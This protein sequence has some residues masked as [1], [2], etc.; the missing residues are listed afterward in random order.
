MWIFTT[1]GFFSIV[2]KKGEPLLTVRAR[3][4]SDLDR[5]REEY[6]PD[7]SE[8]ISGAGT[9]YLYR[10]TIGH[11]SFS[12]GIAKMAK[13]IH[14]DNFKN[15]IGKAM[16]KKRE[17]IYLEIWE[18]LLKL[19]KQEGPGHFP[20]V[21]SGRGRRIAYGG[22]V[23]NGEGKI[24]LREPKNHFD[25]YVWTFPKGSPNR[26]ESP[27]DTALREVFE[28]TG[29]RAKI[30]GRLPGNYEGGTSNNIYFLMSMIEDTGKLDDETKSIYW[31]APSEAEEMLTKT[32][33]AVGRTRDLKV[34]RDV[35]KRRTG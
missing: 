17:S 11:E 25:G 6:M 2:Q 29:I 1:V 18:T 31:A 26:G 9:D 30:N 12:R 35:L 7:L 34:L 8:T 10:A 33:N 22:V 32:S 21:K 23:F 28:E 14:Y 5:L 4:A 15:E 24:L 19:Q 3:V 20:G 27:E 16:G 13:E